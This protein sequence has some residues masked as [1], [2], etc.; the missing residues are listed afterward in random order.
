[1]G[2]FVLERVIPDDVLAML[3]EECAT[4][5]A[6]MDARMDR[7]GTPTIDLNHRGSRYFISKQYRR[8]GRLRSFLFGALMAEVAEAALGPEAF[9]FNEQWV[10]KGADRGMKFAW[11]QD[12]GYIRHDDPTNRHAPYLTCWCPLDDVTTENGAVHLLPHSRGGTRDTVFDHVREAGTNDLVGYR[13]DD[14]GVEMTAPA[15]SIV[16]FT[17]YNLHRSGA[18]RTASARRVYLAQYSSHPITATDGTLW[19]MAVPFLR[20]G[21]VVYDAAG[22]SAERFGPLPGR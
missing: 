4:F 6:A 16:A 17:S 2:Y 22:D 1:E 13:G 12:S 19:A 3:R 10:V 14:P 5:V 18:N 21:G 11:H 15:G 7:L 9:L 20:D 8:S